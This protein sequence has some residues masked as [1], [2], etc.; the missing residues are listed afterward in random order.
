MSSHTWIPKQA[1]GAV[2]SARANRHGLM[3]MHWR[4]LCCLMR[5]RLFHALSLV[6]SMPPILLL[7]DVDPF[8]FALPVPLTVSQHIGLTRRLTKT[9][10]T[11]SR[12][13]RLS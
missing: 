4:P 5:R 11:K 2:Y 1:V 3:K 10:K 8:H 12:T 7:F 9:R 6:L 13:W